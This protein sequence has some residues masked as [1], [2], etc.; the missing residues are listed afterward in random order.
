MMRVMI[1][2]NS[3]DQLQ[4]FFQYLNGDELHPYQKILGCQEDLEWHFRLTS[5]RRCQSRRVLP[6]EWDR[7]QATDFQAKNIARER[8]NT[9][10]NIRWIC[11]VKNAYILSSLNEPLDSRVNAGQPQEFVVQNQ[12]LPF[13]SKDLRRQSSQIVYR[14]V[15]VQ[16]R[17]S[18]FYH[19]RKSPQRH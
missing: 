11:G 10:A 19:S 3:L 16:A 15:K 7:C 4:K 9:N 2:D 18:S 1:A 13:L 14:L 8:F 12:R 6:L 17:W 5:W